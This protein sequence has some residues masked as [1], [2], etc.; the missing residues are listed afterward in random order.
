MKAKGA[1]YRV[2]TRV[3]TY[4]LFAI[5]VI[6]NIQNFIHFSYKSIRIHLLI[7]RT[8]HIL[9]IQVINI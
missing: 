7:K 2:C 5:F 4:V 1:C 8:L 3:S 9:K 6:L